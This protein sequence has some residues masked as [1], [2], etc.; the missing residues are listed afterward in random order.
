MSS[1]ATAWW[2]AVGSGDDGGIE[3]DRLQLGERAAETD[4]T[5]VTG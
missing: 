2:V 5:E 4:R 3:V 1:S